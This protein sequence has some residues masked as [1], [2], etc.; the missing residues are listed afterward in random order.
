MFSFLLLFA[1]PP[2]W[3]EKYGMV[4]A[5]VGGGQ[6]IASSSF[7]RRGGGG[8]KEKVVPEGGEFGEEVEGVC[9][10]EGGE[11]QEQER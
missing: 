6:G 1:W 5:C 10:W 7:G 2:C 9:W 3:S 4:T 8:L 11:E